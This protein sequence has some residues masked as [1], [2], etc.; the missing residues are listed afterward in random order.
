MRLDVTVTTALAVTGPA[1]PRLLLTGLLALTAG[2]ALL[3]TGHT[4]RPGSP[5]LPAGV[6][7]N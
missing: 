3:R 4:R 2:L 1:T 5:L 6:A 7:Y